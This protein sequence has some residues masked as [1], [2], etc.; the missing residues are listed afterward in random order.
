MKFTIC[1]CLIKNKLQKK[2]TQD[3][4]QISTSQ[5]KK[6]QDKKEIA[7]FLFFVYNIYKDYGK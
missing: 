2:Q 7:N 3:L 6:L 4:E 1:I 5:K